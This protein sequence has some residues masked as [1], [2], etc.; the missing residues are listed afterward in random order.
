MLIGLAAG[1]LTGVLWGLTFVAPRAVEPY[2]A[3]DITVAR[4]V[5]FGVIS[6]GL[7]AWPRFQPRGMSRR[8]TA[9]GFLLG[10]FSYTG[11]SL[12]IAF[13]VKNAG[14]AVPPLIVGT[15]PV[16]LALIGN[17]AEK[18][19]SWR[20]LILPLTLIL[21]GVFT[22]NGAALAA[23]GLAGRDHILVGTG[24][25][26]LS[27]ALWVAYGAANTA[28]MRS[29]RAPTSLRWTCLQGLGALVGSLVLLPLSGLIEPGAGTR[30]M[31]TPEG[32]RFLAWVAVMGVGGSWFASWAWVVASQRLPLALAAQLV[33]FE[34]IFG[35]MD[36]FLFEGR[37]PSP[38]EWVGS[39]L[40]LVGVV[41]GIY[42][43]TR[44]PVPVATVP[45][46]A[47]GPPAP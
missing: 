28:V 38:A 39:A 23:V 20:A 6:V 31:S 2:T 8:I 7:M 12:S 45:L 46:P 24:W 18:S 26:V 16:L 13:A 22:V 27:L 5:I 1:I 42:V 14:A 9:A 10:V 47:G 36:G 30:L 21:V 25:A 41:A 4:Y 3:W 34:T 29:P 17:L 15:M 37:W 44:P 32:W 40:Q 33:V 19:V 43:F 11:Y 35:L